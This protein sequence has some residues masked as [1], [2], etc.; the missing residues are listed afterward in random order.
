[1]I[2]DV[3]AFSQIVI[4]CQVVPGFL[5][6]AFSCGTQIEVSPSVGCSVTQAVFGVLP[7]KAGACVYIWGVCVRVHA[8]ETD[9]GHSHNPPLTRW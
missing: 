6:A 8:C 5:P 7:G 9:R 4:W 1:M 2:P 3:P